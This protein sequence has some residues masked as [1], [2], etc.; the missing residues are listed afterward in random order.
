MLSRVI[1]EARD[2]LLKPSGEVL[3]VWNKSSP[4]VSLNTSS[5]RNSSPSLG[6]DYVIDPTT[7]TS[8]AAG[9][10]D[11][12]DRMANSSSISTGIRAV[13]AIR[14]SSVV[15]VPAKR[16]ATALDKAVIPTAGKKLR[17]GLVGEEAT[18]DPISNGYSS[19]QDEAP[20]F[21]S[22]APSHF[23]SQP[24]PSCGGVFDRNKK[25]RGAAGARSKIRRKLS[26]SKCP[27]SE[28]AS[29]GHGLPKMRRFAEKPASVVQFSSIHGGSFPRLPYDAPR[30]CVHII[31][32]TKFHTNKTR[33]SI[34]MA[35]LIVTLLLCYC[36]DL[37]Y[38]FLNAN[39]HPEFRFPRIEA[40]DGGRR[41][42][43]IVRT[44]LIM[45]VGGSYF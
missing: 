1:S 7:G 34:W 26:T 38:A 43:S 37:L 35:D 15:R 33:S 29:D 6:F 40:V 19:E 2:L 14:P 11:I 21:L 16:K 36:L 41:D 8:L 24:G 32:V 22:T 3:S 23:E 28:G 10:S 27:L 42:F 4:E 30:G 31:D 20:L 17:I 9:E 18:L 45:T 12:G 13:E 5:N 25:C 39:R 44:G